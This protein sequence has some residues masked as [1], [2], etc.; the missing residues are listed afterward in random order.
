MLLKDNLQNPGVKV[1]QNPRLSM[2]SLESIVV[3][4]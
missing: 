2:N 4:Q 3:L 1:L